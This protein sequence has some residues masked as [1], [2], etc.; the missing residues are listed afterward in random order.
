MS[1]VQSKAKSS[2]PD[3]MQ[4]HLVDQRPNQS[5]PIRTEDGTKFWYLLKIVKYM[6]LVRRK[7]CLFYINLTN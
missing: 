5:H 3:P 6:L 4:S 2:D 7:V 1:P